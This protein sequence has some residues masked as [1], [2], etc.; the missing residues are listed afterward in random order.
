MQTL[1][2]KLDL[3]DVRRTSP[4]RLTA[5]LGSVFLAAIFL[6]LGLI[7]ALTER[8]LVTRTDRVLAL[9]SRT[10]RWP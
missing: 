5:L 1:T 10:C 3:G 8:E 2:D 4:F 6:L 7:Y 9:E